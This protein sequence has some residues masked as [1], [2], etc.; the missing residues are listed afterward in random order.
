MPN[1]ANFWLDYLKIKTEGI[2]SESF[3]KATIYFG[4]ESRTKE[5]KRV[6]GYLSSVSDEILF[7][8]GK[9]SKIDSI[10]VKWSSGNQQT[11]YNINANKT[12]IVKEQEGLKN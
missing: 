10:K 4:K 6:R 3:A 2:L 12:I 7:G 5:S 11:L 1:S 9:T 8:L